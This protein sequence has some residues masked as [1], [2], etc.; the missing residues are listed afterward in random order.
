MENKN[1]DSDEYRKAMAIASGIS[2]PIAP[3]L[4][5]L[6]REVAN[7]ANNI[8]IN[9]AYLEALKPIVSCGSQ[10]SRI[11]SIAQQLSGIASM[12]Q[13]LS[14]LFPVFTMSEE[15]REYIEE[16]KECEKLSEEEFEER[17]GE[18]I[19]DSR[20]LGTNGWVVSGHA[21]PKEIQEWCEAVTIEKKQEKILKFFENNN[22]S[23]IRSI[24]EDLRKKYVQAANISYLDRGNKAFNEEDYNTAAMYWVALLDY[25]INILVQFPKNAIKYKQKFSE[26]GFSEIKRNKYDS[27]SKSLMSKEYFFLRVYPSLIAY[28]NRMF[29][30]GKY[31]FKNKIEPPYINRNW[32]MH[33]RSGRVIERYECIQVLNAIDMIESVFDSCQ[34]RISDNV[35]R[36]E[37]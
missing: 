25:R 20:L 29:V 15:L 35:G 10:L 23:V 12:A 27:I 11:T 6:Q 16:E 7:V 5:E 13:Q 26:D 14:G 2:I 4:V 17:Y 3:Q 31:E 21:T 32:L 34:E 8:K 24:V 18:A 22:C 9:S 36:E 33:G 28:L 1:F 19:A 37:D 30:D